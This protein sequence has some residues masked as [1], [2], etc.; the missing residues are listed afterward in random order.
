[1]TQIDF[2]Q[3]DRCGKL[4]RVE[5]GKIPEHVDMF[6]FGEMTISDLCEDCIASLSF[7]LS[8][9]YYKKFNELTE[10]LVKEEWE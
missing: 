2:Y 1:M 9:K 3:C 5:H 7:W 4:Y 10:K 6:S 8:K